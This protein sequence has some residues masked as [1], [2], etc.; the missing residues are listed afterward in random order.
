VTA[1]RKVELAT[2]LIICGPQ[3]IS[4]LLNWW[5][6]PGRAG[7]AGAALAAGNVA[8]TRALAP[9]KAAAVGSNGCMR[10]YGAETSDPTS[11]RGTRSTATVSI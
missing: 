2:L 10:P 4:W 11:E 7:F 1:S 8:P 6:L 9:L 5:S 3:W